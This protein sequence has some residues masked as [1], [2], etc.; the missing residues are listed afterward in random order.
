MRQSH[1]GRARELARDEEHAELLGRNAFVITML[2]AV[3]FLSACL[4]VMIH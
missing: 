4:Y 2:G 1:G 3:G